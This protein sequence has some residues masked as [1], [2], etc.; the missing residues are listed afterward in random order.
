[1]RRKKKKPK[2][3]LDTMNTA[4]QILAGIANIAFIIYQVLKG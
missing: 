4:V 2:S 1:M 3:K